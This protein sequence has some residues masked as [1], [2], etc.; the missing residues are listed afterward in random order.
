MGGPM[1]F[2]YGKWYVSGESRMGRVG[3]VFSFS[4]HHY[5]LHFYGWQL[6]LSGP[7]DADEFFS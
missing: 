1:N 4:V 3:F 7:V 6:W 2:S 5:G